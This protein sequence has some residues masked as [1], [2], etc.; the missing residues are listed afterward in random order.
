MNVTAP[1]WNPDRYLVAV[2]FAAE[3]HQGQIVP[4]TDLPYLLHVTTV[5]AEVM[6]ALSAE[7]DDD[8]DLAVQCALLH[9]AM[10]DAGVLYE[11]LAERFGAP[12][13]DGVAALSK[14]PEIPKP[15]RM[16]DSLA[17]IRQQPFAAWKVKL[18]DRI[19]NLQ[20][21]PPGWSS[22]KIAAYAEEARLI[23]REL[24][25]AS[26]FLSRRMEAKLVQYEKWISS[27]RAGE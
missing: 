15:E 20:P 9:D 7:I 10:E 2:R 1:P 22:R 6:A 12:V 3:V 5:C 23:L 14:N 18:A 17:R 13:A 11:Q 4:G 26:P 8:P 16:A 27:R 21:P 25:E 24:G 19:T